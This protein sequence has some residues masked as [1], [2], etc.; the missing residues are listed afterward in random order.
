[1]DRSQ[2][3]SRPE[4]APL[5][6]G[7]CSTRLA[8]LHS[9]RVGTNAGL[10]LALGATIVL[11]GLTACAPRRALDI[12]STPPG[13]AVRIDERLV[14]ETPMRYK[15]T[16]YGTRRVTLYKEGYRSTTNLVRLRP[17]WYA[18][19]PLDYI[20][21]LVLPF[22]WKD[23]RQYEVT[24]EE[25]S[26]QVTL[27]DLQ[28]VLDRAELFRLAGPDGPQLTEVIPMEPEPTPD[29]TADDD[30]SSSGGSEKR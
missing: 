20:S 2:E 7:T 19:F 1:M 4:H 8:S 18:R 3:R 25:E 9:A 12:R 14:G 21:E 30:E 29:E 28:G 26:G 27:P 5:R 10:C 23:R 11:G 24:L 15:F 22:G 6:A 17:P 13:A 16:E